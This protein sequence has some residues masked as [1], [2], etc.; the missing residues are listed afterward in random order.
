[1]RAPTTTR[2]WSGR[3]GSP[4]SAPRSRR[5]ATGAPTPRRS[6]RSRVSTGAVRCAW[7]FGLRSSTW[8]RM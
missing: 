5:S 2:S 6:A 1:M 7:T 8:A 3:S 4:A